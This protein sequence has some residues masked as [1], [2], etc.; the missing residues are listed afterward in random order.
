MDHVE[1]KTL[2]LKTESN[3]AANSG[4]DVRL[5]KLAL[6]FASACGEMVDHVKTRAFYGREVKPE[7]IL[8]T[9]G[10]VSDT[11]SALFAHL[12]ITDRTVSLEKPKCSISLIHG[13]LGHI[14][15]AGEMADD[16]ARLISR[17]ED[18]S[19]RQVENVMENLR[20]ECSDHEWYTSIMLDPLSIDRPTLWEKNIAKLKKRFPEGHFDAFRANNRDIDAEKEAFQ[21]ATH[22]QGD[23]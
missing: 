18:L 10:K 12:F 13:T 6:D 4:Y 7:S 5:F 22:R 19:D 11:L 1:Y 14:T 20:Q 21:C 17:D 3:P 15:E 23:V 16:V 9:H 2:C 8:K